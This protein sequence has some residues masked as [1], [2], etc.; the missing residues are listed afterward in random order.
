M[1]GENEVPSP[2]PHYQFLITNLIVILLVV[3]DFVGAE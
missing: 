3:A 1:Q 2:I